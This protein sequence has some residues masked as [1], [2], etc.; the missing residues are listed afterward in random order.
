MP[1]IVSGHEDNYIRFFDINS[2]II[3]IFI[4][5]TCTHSMLAHLDSV[6]SIDISPD[7]NTLVSGG[8]YKI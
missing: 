7:G 3:I 4:I 5:G 1:L 8:K 6:S 2:G